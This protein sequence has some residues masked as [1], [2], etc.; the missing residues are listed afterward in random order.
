M[1]ATKSHNTVQ[2]RCAIGVL[3][4]LSMSA[5]LVQSRRSLSFKKNRRGIGLIHVNLIK[6]DVLRYWNILHIITIYSIPM[7]DGIYICF[8]S[9][10]QNRY[11]KTKH[12][13]SN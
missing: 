2:C 7:C 1:T 11:S 13:V 4:E 3:I 6:F 9:E 12:L 10:I 8:A 5:A